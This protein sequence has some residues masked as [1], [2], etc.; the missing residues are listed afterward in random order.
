LEESLGRGQAD[1]SAAARDQDTL[2][3][4]PPHPRSRLA[5]RRV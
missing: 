1:P 2:A 3:L 5:R 4:Q